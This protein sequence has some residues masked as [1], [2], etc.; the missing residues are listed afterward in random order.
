MIV[1]NTS[2]ITSQNPSGF[3]VEKFITVKAAAEVS[4]YNIQY[5]RRLLRGEK[6]D[7]VKVGQLWLIKLAS[8]EAF[9]NRTSISIDSRCGPKG[10][11]K[12]GSVTTANAH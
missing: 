12:A 8:F 10:L 4:G 6:L 3:L 5:L 9:L 2:N 7:S 1:L 11:Q